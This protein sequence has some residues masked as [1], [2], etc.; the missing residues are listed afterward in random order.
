VEATLSKI[1]SNIHTW[2]DLRHA[3]EKDVEKR[4]KYYKA[5]RKAVSKHSIALSHDDDV[6]D[7]EAVAHADG[8]AQ[9]RA[10]GPETLLQVRAGAGF[11]WWSQ[12]PVEL[13]E[14]LDNLRRQGVVLEEA[15]QAP[16]QAMYAYLPQAQ[17]QPMTA[18]QAVGGQYAYVPA[19]PEMQA[20]S[21]GGQVPQAGQTWSPMQQQPVQSQMM[22]Q[23]Q[24]VTSLKHVSAC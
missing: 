14:E 18:Q 17:A 7:D 6:D 20:A 9:D 2:K 11:S 21:G 10:L 19:N 23:Q 24:Q 5:A 12:R 8:A 4:A 15:H 1:A 13:E 3:D 22:Q 16:Q